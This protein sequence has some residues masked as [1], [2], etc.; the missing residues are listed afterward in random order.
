MNST[1]S[2]PRFFS[3][4][5]LV[6]LASVLAVAQQARGTLRGV[7]IDELGAVIVGANVTLTDTSG[8][9]K[10]T[11]TNAEGV[12]TFNGLA[13]G[14]YSLQANAPGFAPSDEKQIDVT[15]G[16]QSVDLTLKVTIEE[17]VTVQETPIST[18]ATNNANQ[19]VLSGKDL[20]ALPDDPDELAAALQALAGPSVGPN[21]GQIFIDG[22][23]GGN[24]PSKDSIREIRI[25]QNPFAAENDQPSARIDILT[26]PGTDK[27]RGGSFFNFTDESLNSRNPFAI[28]SSKRAPFQIR[29]YDVNFSGPVIPRKAS[30]FV[31][32]GR[33]ET[34]DNELI[35]ATVL[36][37]NLNRLDIGQGFVTPKRNTF[38]SPRFDY[39]INNNHTLIA[40]Y[41]FNRFTFENQGVGG[42]SLPERAYDTV[43]TTHTIQLTE[44]AILN[45]TTIN[46]TRFQYTFGR[47]EQLGDSSVPALNVSGS[48]NSGSSQVGNSFNERRAW[49]LNNFTAKQRGTHAIKFGGRVRHVGVDD[50]NEN[51]FG[52]TWSF[53]GGFGLTSL[54][55]YQLTLRM[56]EQ[57]FTPE[58]IRAAGGG[59]ASFS[60]N[61]GNPFATVDQTDLGVFVQD[62][63]RIRPN[64]TLS[65]GLRY[66]IQT[67]T[68]SKYD[69][70]PRVAMAWSP[71]A[72][73]SAR[74]PKMVIRF[75][76]GFFYNRFSEGS[77]LTVN[78]NN[79]VNLQQT[80]ITEEA[81]R[82]TP[83]TIAEQQAPNVAAAYAILNQWSPTSVPDV[84]AIPPTQQI[85]WTK[86]PNI[87]NPTV[88][89]A[90]TQVERQLPRNITMFVG[91]Y[92]IRITHVIRARDV[93]APLPGT[94]TPLN[95]LGIRPDP[96]QGEV[97][98]FEA[99]GQFNQR[100]L[101]VGFNT[102]LSRMF[103]LNGNYSWSK[104]TNDTDGQGGQLFPM[105]SYDTSGEFGRSSFDIRHR[106]TIFGTVNLPWWKIVMSPFVVANTGPPF[107][108]VTGQDLNLDRQITERPSLLGPEANCLLKTVKCTR[109]GNFNLVPLTGER[110]IPR[111]Y[112]QS[113]GSLV[114]NLRVG[115]TFAFG[116]INRGNAAAA[117]PAGGAGP[118][119]PG[120]TAAAAPGGPRLATAGPG[121]PQ[122]PGGAPSEKR[123]TLN[124]SLYF[125]NILNHVNLSQPVGNLSSPSFGE[126]LGLSSTATQFGGPGGGGS[127]G[128]GNRRIYAQL[129]LNF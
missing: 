26:R 119:G 94:I 64:I 43:S 58:Q 72:A 113:P 116:T 126:S 47:N 9:Q 80:F 105:N 42:F 15:A 51:N 125:Q 68:D 90:G 92:N 7:I 17:K 127:A 111:N 50:S 21:G 46:E 93:N 32:F 24:L 96:A 78:R 31:S 87:Q 81:R 76:T 70:A 38:F 10:K 49:E 114:V 73:N 104:T 74:P 59:A 101:F 99:S 77:T 29:Q 61:S 13:P 18:E 37:E 108:I 107:N 124:V 100:Q 91:F 89:V 52:G 56:Q 41:N 33:I 12:Y 48:F 62:D 63:W 30:F 67:N 88:W 53:T 110:I 66:E 8:A 55:R 34:D 123:F 20:D 115:R 19:T 121:G 86:D 102:R 129:R 45:P 1:R 6:L 103:Q 44:T 65:Y 79:G 120:A 27:F 57:G 16:R 25:N 22:F 117:R 122:G 5:L 11:T 39:S 69:F 109:F 118:S 106:F 40:R 83:P 84:S 112:G 85:V 75:G 23:T 60:I 2:L 97:Y 82:L 28:S 36:D 35:R 3:A 71:G 54:Q 98:R 128:A 14:K 95:E 4:F